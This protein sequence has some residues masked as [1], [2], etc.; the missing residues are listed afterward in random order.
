MLIN[1]EKTFQS[2]L[3][4]LYWKKGGRHRLVKTATQKITWLN[5]SVTS[6]FSLN[7][8][9]QLVVT[10]SFKLRLFFFIKKRLQMDFH[11]GLSLEGEDSFIASWHFIISATYRSQVVSVTSITIRLPLHAND[12]RRTPSYPLQS[13]PPALRDPKSLPPPLCL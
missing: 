13:A 6:L 4:K 7:T 9:V 11:R 12:Q 3:S 2:F 10:S 1:F 5:C 8:V